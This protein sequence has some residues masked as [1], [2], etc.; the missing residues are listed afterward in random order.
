M[1]DSDADL[2]VRW[3]GGDGAAGERL[4]DRYYKPLQRF[5]M[6]KSVADPV[7]MVQ[8]TFMRMLESQQR[9]RDSSKFRS[10]LFSVAY[11]VLRMYW[12]GRGKANAHIDLSEQSVQDLAPGPG[13]LT[14]KKREQRLLLE[15]LR[16]IPMDSQ[17]IIEMMYWEDMSSFEIAEVL[18][19]PAGTVR[20]RMRRARELLEQAMTRLAASPEVLHSTLSNL[21]DW[22]RQCKR[23]AGSTD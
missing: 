19:I 13:T 16:H 23:A 21:E 9:L 4:F 17:I 6:S 14:S 15:A 7:E 1:S 18:G 2:L 11:S 5:F 12:R 3:R 20:G 8:D 10:Y 22:A